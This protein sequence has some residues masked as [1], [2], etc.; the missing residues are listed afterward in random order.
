MAI[1]IINTVTAQQA[2]IQVYEGATTTFTATALD[3]NSSP[4]NLTGYS[5]VLTVKSKGTDTSSKL[6]FTSADSSITIGGTGHNVVTFSKISAI[7]GG[8]YVYDCVATLPDNV[9]KQPWIYG[10]FIVI[11]SV[12]NIV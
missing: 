10:Q 12:S 11:Q 5:F 4:I 3:D 7:K 2:T 6:V 9:T 8:N 1:P